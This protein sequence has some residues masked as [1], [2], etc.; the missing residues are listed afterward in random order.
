MARMTEKEPT[1][2]FM[3][4]ILIIVMSPNVAAEI[5]QNA[6]PTSYAHRI[7]KRMLPP[8]MPARMN[9]PERRLNAI[10][11]SWKATWLETKLIE[12]L[13]DALGKTKQTPIIPMATTPM[14]MKK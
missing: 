7:L 1:G 6:I 14:K 11:S 10:G 8:T 2:E 12:I 13:L 5:M 9:S 4:P 3:T